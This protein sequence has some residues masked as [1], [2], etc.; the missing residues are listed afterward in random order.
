MLAAI[1]RVQPPQP[2]AQPQ[3][4]PG[5]FA[6]AVSRV[7]LIKDAE[8]RQADVRDFLIPQRDFG[9]HRLGIKAVFRV[10]VRF[11]CDMETPSMGDPNLVGMY[12]IGLQ[13]AIRWR[14]VGVPAAPVDKVRMRYLHDPEHCE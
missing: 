5:F 14:A 1:R 6:L 4:P 13:L 11:A 10:K 8:R 7:F 9:F 12:Y 3:P 2:W